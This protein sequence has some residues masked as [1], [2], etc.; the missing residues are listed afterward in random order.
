MSR[1]HLFF[2]ICTKGCELKG[3]SSVW[4]ISAFPLSTASLCVSEPHIPVPALT[5][6]LS[7]CLSV[8]QG[9][10]MTKVIRNY[11][12]MS[13]VLLQYELLHLQAWSEAAESVPPCLNAALL[14]R[15]ENSKVLDGVIIDQ[16]MS[17]QGFK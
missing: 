2:A 17:E 13:V 14:V 3:P 6:C 9:P 16:W 15:H 8:C 12:K 11:N 1:I 7:V 4:S 10:E 5:P